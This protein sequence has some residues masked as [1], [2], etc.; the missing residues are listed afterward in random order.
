[1]CHPRKPHYLGKQVA[2]AGEEFL[3]HEILAAAR[4][5]LAGSGLIRQRL[6]MMR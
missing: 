2:P 1:M 5:Q 6:A 3:F 4:R